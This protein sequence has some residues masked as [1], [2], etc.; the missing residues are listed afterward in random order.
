MEFVLS[1]YFVS[2][3]CCFFLPFDGANIQRTVRMKRFGVLFW[4]K[5]LSIIIKFVFEYSFSYD[6]K[7]NRGV[8]VIDYKLC[9]ICFVGA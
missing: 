3:D 1:F 6:M 2:F 8:F 7:C 5:K 9:V 4:R